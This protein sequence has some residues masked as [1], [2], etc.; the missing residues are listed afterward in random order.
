MKIVC[1]TVL[2]T[3]AHIAPVIA[4]GLPQ[5]EATCA[6]TRIA[7]LEHRLQTGPGAFVPDSGSAV[8]YAN[9]GYQVSYEELPSIAASRT[10]DAV[11]LCLIR[12]PRNCPPGDVRGRIYTAT[13]MRTLASWTLPDSE[14]GCGGA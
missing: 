1:L 3:A 9:S 7:R 10:G 14:H 2:L 12:V 13:N 6:V 4:Q 8:R 5:R 11:T